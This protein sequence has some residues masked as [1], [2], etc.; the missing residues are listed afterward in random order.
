MVKARMA[1]SP[2]NVAWATLEPRTF[3]LTRRVLHVG[4]R[5]DH[6][7]QRVKRHYRELSPKAAL[8][9][10]HWLASVD[11]V[12]PASNKQSAIGKRA[13]AGSCMTRSP[14]WSEA[15]SSDHSL[16]VGRVFRRTPWELARA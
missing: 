12:W 2:E 9:L 3:D 11:K 7:R 15:S 4:E 13:R 10:G 16:Y 1:K 8:F 6:A 5:W 14:S